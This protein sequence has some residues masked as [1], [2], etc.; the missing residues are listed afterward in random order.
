V[1]AHWTLGVPTANPSDTWWAELNPDVGSAHGLPS[2]IFP[3]DNWWNVNVS[4]APLSTSP[5]SSTF[6]NIWNTSNSNGLYRLFNGNAN[7]SVGAY[8]IPFCVVG[9]GVDQVSSG[10]VTWIEFSGVDY[11]SES[12]WSGNGSAWYQGK[13]PI[14]TTAISTIGWHEEVDQSLSD[15]TTGPDRHMMIYNRQNDYLY[16]LYQPFYNNS[17]SSVELVNKPGTF[18][19]AHEWHCANVSVWDTTTNNYRTNGWTSTDAAGLQILP[20]IIRYDELVGAGAPATVTHAYRFCIQNGMLTTPCS[21]WPATHYAPGSR[22]SDMYPPTGARLR[23]KA[24]FNISGYAAWIQKFFQA[25]KDYGMICA[26][27][28]TALGGFDIPGTYDTRWGEYDQSYAGALKTA[29]DDTTKNDFEMIEWNWGMPGG[30]QNL[31]I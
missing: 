23:L 1:P 21:R 29:C 14:P 25:L 19:G 24:S 28:G 12:D 3:S 15:M 2:Q 8:G 4:A 31:T 5:A 17:G 10:Q 11:S 22:T 27:Y 30:F 26:D 20:G 9:G 16:E 13:V 18:V 6:M 7:P